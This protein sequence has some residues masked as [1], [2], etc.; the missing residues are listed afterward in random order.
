MPG[1]ATRSSQR[2][3]VRGMLNVRATAAVD[4]GRRLQTAASCTSGSASRPGMC[5]PR[6]L[7]PAPIRPTRR[8]DGDRAVVLGVFR[9]CS[10]PTEVDVDGA[11]KRDQLL[12]RQVSNLPL[13]GKLETCRHNHVRQLLFPPTDIHDV[14]NTVAET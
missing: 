5:L 6:V 3:K 1:S 11:A 14:H 8:V 13:I 12:W 7:A 9:K 4:S 10:K 2:S